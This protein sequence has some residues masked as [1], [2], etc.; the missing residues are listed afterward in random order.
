M[1][2]KSRPLKGASVSPGCK[3]ETVAGTHV[4][5]TAVRDST[6]GAPQA[7]CV[8]VGSQSAVFRADA[9][10]KDEWVARALTPPQINP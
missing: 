4:H 6:G 5:V 7:S 10:W 3:P 2:R 1:T 8:G 9:L